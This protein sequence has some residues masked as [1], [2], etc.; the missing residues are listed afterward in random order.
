MR[1]RGANHAPLV[2][3]PAQFCK[4]GLRVRQGK[5][6]QGAK[7]VREAPCHCGVFVVRQARSF[8][9]IRPAFEV[10][11]RRGYGEDLHPDPGGIHQFE[12]LAKLVIRRPRTEPAMDRGAAVSKPDKKIEISLAP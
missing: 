7:A 9:G 2:E 10:R 12:P 5:S 4:C 1:D 11:R 8:H 6:R 3:G